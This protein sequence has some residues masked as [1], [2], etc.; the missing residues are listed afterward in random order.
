[1]N[2]KICSTCI[3][4]ILAVTS[5]SLKD[6]LLVQNEKYF[7]TGHEQRGPEISWVIVSAVTLVALIQEFVKVV[8]HDIGSQQ[9]RTKQ[10]P[11]SDVSRWC[12][13]EIVFDFIFN[14]YNIEFDEEQSKERYENAENSEICN[15]QKDWP[16]LESIIVL[17]DE[18]IVALH[19]QTC[20]VKYNG[21]L[22]SNGGF[23]IELPSKNR[24]HVQCHP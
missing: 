10:S 7:Q 14:F 4:Q 19:D 13:D 1:M 8:L 21:N 23:E 5:P 2:M 18:P 11:L 22:G 6:F 17:V 15:V 20:F 12:Q 3:S 16:C 9:V 24:H